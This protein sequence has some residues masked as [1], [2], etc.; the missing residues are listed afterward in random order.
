MI[1]DAAGGL[2]ARVNGGRYDSIRELMASDISSPT[3]AG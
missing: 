1:M 2:W 3:S